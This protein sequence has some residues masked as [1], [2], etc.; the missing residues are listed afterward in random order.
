MRIMIIKPGILNTWGRYSVLA[1]SNTSKFG[2]IGI[3][4]SLLSNSRPSSGSVR[5][6][7]SIPNTL[8]SRFSLSLFQVCLFFIDCSLCTYCPFL[9]LW[10]TEDMVEF[11][12]SL[13]N[14]NFLVAQNCIQIASRNISFFLKKVTTILSLV[15]KYCISKRHF[16]WQIWLST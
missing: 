3:L 4:P 9:L 1:L 16:L 5:F 12:N 14:K 13:K 8:N 11:Y 15:F 6:I 7:N 10:A 2:A